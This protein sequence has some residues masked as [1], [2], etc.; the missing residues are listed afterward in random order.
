MLEVGVLGWWRVRFDLMF[1]V[2]GILMVPGMAR[3]WAIL[4]EGEGGTAKSTWLNLQRRF[5]GRQHVSTLSLQMLEANRFATSRLVGKLANIYADLPD[6]HLETTPIFRSI[7]GGDSVPAEFKHM[8]GFDFDPMVR[9]VFSANHY[10]KSADA[11]SAFF[12][13]WIVLPF[14]RRFRDTPFER[15]QNELLDSL[16]TPVEMSG[17]LNEALRGLARFVNR[18]NRYEI[19]ASVA[20]AIKV[21]RFGD[22]AVI[23]GEISP[24]GNCP[25]CGAE[26]ELFQLRQDKWMVCRRDKARW[27]IGWGL[28]TG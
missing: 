25:R 14:E 24:F 21:L 10:P 2:T 23:V 19:P 28:F 4:V 26:G 18:G 11:S 22:T 9:L 5:L 17:M 13:R 27:H 15:E 7:T 16:S 12:D 8:N 20:V 6:T 3:R 1:E